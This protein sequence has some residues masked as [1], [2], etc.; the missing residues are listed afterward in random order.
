MLIDVGSDFRPTHS[1]LGGPEGPPYVQ[2]APAEVI[3]DIRVHGNHVTTDDEIIKISSV[4]IGAPFTSTTVADV[5][6]KL[7]AS[8][9][10]DDVSVLKRFASIED[11]SKILLVLVV[12]EGPVRIDVPKDKD[13]PITVVRRRGIKNLMYMPIFDA[14][15]GYG[16]TAGVRLAYVG[17]AGKRSRFSFPLT[18][19]G[20]KKVGAEFDRTF[21]RGP[22]TRIEVGS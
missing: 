12:N 3:S 14:E 4:T 6:S 21:T 2:T 10:F 20:T 18:F 1:D 17:T 13:A 19:G 5:T 15:D 7:K 22:I 9:K 8:K 11:P 16:V